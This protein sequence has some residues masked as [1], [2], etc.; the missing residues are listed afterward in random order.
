MAS[1]QDSQ[2]ASTN[3]L[4][5]P[6]THSSDGSTLS[7]SQQASSTDLDADKDPLPEGWEERQVANGRIFY[8][9]HIN[10]RTQWSRPRR[11]QIETDRRRV[12]ALTLAK[13]N[14]GMSDSEVWMQFF[15]NK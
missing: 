6:A 4:V 15:K 11:A 10:R 7:I 8:V 12:M 13:R 1:Q 3:S 14:P 2:A 5:S 9:D